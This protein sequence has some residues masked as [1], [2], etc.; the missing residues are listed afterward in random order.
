MTRKFVFQKRFTLIELLVVIAIIAILAAMLLPAL[1]TAR[2]KAYAAQC[3]SNL[4]QL[5]QAFNMYAMVSDDYIV[6][7]KVKSGHWWF[8]VLNGD[9]PGG[10]K[11]MYGVTR[12]GYGDNSSVFACPAS[13]RKLSAAST[14]GKT[15]QTT[16]YGTHFVINA[17]M[18]AGSW[19]DVNGVGTGGKFRRQ[20]HIT[21][22]SAAVS[23]G[24]TVC[25]YTF[26]GNHL[27]FLAFRH[28]GKDEF[29][30][31]STGWTQPADKSAK[32][33]LLY[34]DGHVGSSSYS[35]LRAIPKPADCYIANSAGA[36]RSGPDANWMGVG[37]NTRAGAPQG[38]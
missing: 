24:D 34:A 11:G 4:K 17:Y 38:F 26:A 25:S 7:A 13:T 15:S 35:E 31:L 37:Y 29:R 14:Y 5:G 12:N 33:N 19:G 8:Q 27:C 10:T 6:P 28:S 20:N 16:F 36:D 21:Q 9:A 23:L 30:D 1:N 22:P 18:H 3:A 2:S 32:A